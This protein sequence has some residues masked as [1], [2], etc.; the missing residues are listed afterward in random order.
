M[1]GCLHRLRLTLAVDAVED[2]RREDHRRRRAAHVKASPT[3][4]GLDGQDSGWVELEFFHPDPSGD[5]W[6]GVFSPA[7]F[8]VSL[9]Q[10]ED[11]TVADI[12]LDNAI[13]RHKLQIMAC[14]ASDPGLEI[15]V[16]LIH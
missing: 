9:N 2:R 6:I 8:R 13:G 4:L 5:D 10:E 3:V 12:I 11:Y 1:D 15:T 14:H 16:L 7:N